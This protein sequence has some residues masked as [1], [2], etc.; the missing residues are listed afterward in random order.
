MQSSPL[1]NRAASVGSNPARSQSFLQRL[2]KTSAFGATDTDGGGAT[3]ESKFESSPTV[4][5]F[6][7][8]E[9]QNPLMKIEDPVTSQPNPEFVITKAVDLSD[10]SLSHSRRNTKQEKSSRNMS[11]NTSQNNT[12]Y[13]LPKNT[14]MRVKSLE[15]I[16]ETD[17][18]LFREL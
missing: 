7:S 6:M 14:I 1:K 13:S 9:R 3:S 10:N 11:E 5:P 16:E 2:I 12:Q 18:F 15:S 4:A 8:L 17:S